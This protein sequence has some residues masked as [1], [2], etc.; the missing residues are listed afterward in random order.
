LYPVDK[1]QSQSIPGLLPGENFAWTTDPTF[2]YVSQWKQPTMRIY[3][4][5]IVTGQRQLFKEVN[6]LDTTGLCDLSHI[7][8]SADGRAYVYG[9]TRLLSDLYL[10]K[11]VPSK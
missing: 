9:Y 4:L 2:M 5:N 8:L 7:L 11:G 6:P 3:R 10:V 1:G